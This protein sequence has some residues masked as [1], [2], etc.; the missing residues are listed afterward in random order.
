MAIALTFIISVTVVIAAGIYL[1]QSAQEIASI[2]QIDALFI[3]SLLLATATSLPEFMVNVNAMF[4]DHYDMA[5]GNLLGSCLFNILILS[6]VE[7][8]FYHKTSTQVVLSKPQIK[9][10]Y[11][12]ILLTFLV[13][14]SLSFEA[15]WHPIP[16]GLCLWSAAIFLFY[17][18][19]LKKTFMLSDFQQDKNNKIPRLPLLKA[20]LTYLGSA[21][22][23]LLAAPHV[24][25]SA[26]E[27][28]IITKL[29]DSFI[30]TTLLALCTSLPELVSSI[31]AWRIGSIDLAIG[32]IFGSN[33]F[34]ILLIAPLDLSSKK[35]F[36]HNLSPSHL[37]TCYC[38]LVS[39]FL[40][41]FKNSNFFSKRSQ[42]YAHPIM[43]ISFSLMSLLVIYHF[44]K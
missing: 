2:T 4:S 33:A 20:I 31:A 43:V 27:I 29:G 16:F 36:F 9:A 8:Y 10:I 6:G 42:G 39:S 3:G 11:F 25:S 23:I 15:I 7:L 22:L 44:S 41:L 40:V 30:G 32:N 1:T 26:A 17:T 13:V 14:F 18:L 5:M 35:S 21:S 38:I 24:A 19:G 28:A 12:S 34:N 37:I